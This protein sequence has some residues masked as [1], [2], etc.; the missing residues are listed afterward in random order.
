MNRFVN[1]SRVLVWPRTLLFSS[2]IGGVL[3]PPAGW[4]QSLPPLMDEATSQSLVPTVD[5]RSL[6]SRVF[7]PHYPTLSLSALPVPEPIFPET[8]PE[9]QL[10]IR[11]SE[12]RVYVYQDNQIYIS[13]PI[14]IG[15]SGWET[16]T[17]DYEVLNMV[18]NPGWQNPF[19]GEVVPPGP[20]NPLGERWIGFWTDGENFI[21]FHGTPNAQSVGQAASHGC[22]RMYNRDVQDLFEI[23]ALGTPVTVQP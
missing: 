18:K 1:F 7:Q 11:L 2:V 9:I 23:V 12:R 22:I 5:V 3:A 21:G 15:R 13:Y 17:G 4:A 19:T 14:A 16:P 8:V 10:V 20:N 6:P